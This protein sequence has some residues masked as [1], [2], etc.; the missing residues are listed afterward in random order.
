MF[1][2]RRLFHCLA[3]LLV[4]AALSLVAAPALAWNAAG[5]R[6]VA[7]I[8]WQELSP[9][10]RQ[11]AAALLQQHPDYRKWTPRSQQDWA[12]ADYHA[13]VE[14]STWADEIRH[15]WRFHDDEQRPTARIPGFPDMARHSH[16]HFL[17]LD[18]TAQGRN[19]G[20][21]EL[22]SVLE[23]LQRQLP[24]RR[25]SYRAYVLPWLIHLVADLHQPLH[26]GGRNDAGGN[27]VMV[28]DP[29]RRPPEV[30]LHAWWDQ[31]GGPPSLRGRPLEAEVARLRRSYPG[32][33]KSG[34]ARSWRDESFR[35]ARDLAYPPGHGDNLRIDEA[36]RRQAEAASDRRLLEAGLRLGDLLNHLLGR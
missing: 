24:D 20:K 14:C 10:A 19:D 26:V 25:Y 6:I 34:N 8:A 13:F 23:Q 35:L 1:A 15:D 4:G 33:S 22:E 11:N 17:N 5:H 32:V 7:A 30:N 18:V 36:W 16:W 29:R 9:A 2:L 21:G 3:P 28:F 27:R 12:T 31:L